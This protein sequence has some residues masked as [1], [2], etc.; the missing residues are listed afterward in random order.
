VAIEPARSA[1]ERVHWTLW[2]SLLV[3]LAVYALLPLLMTPPGGGDGGVS[4]VLVAA[5]AMAAV[6][7]GVASFAIRRALLT[8][9]VRRGQLDPDRPRDALRVRGILIA[10]W[11]ACEAVAIQGLV[12]F[13]LGAPL[14]VVFAFFAAGALLMLLHAP[15]ARAWRRPDARDLARPDVR[16]G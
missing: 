4:G 5:L 16:I 12:L 14:A 15:R 8:G 7:L 10:C 13:F 1:A 11:V 2:A 3:S 6:M 9:P